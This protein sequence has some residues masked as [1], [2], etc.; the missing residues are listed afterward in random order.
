MIRS[1]M[2]D[3]LNESQ[4]NNQNLARSFSTGKTEFEELLK[5][6]ENKITAPVFRQLSSFA[7]IFSL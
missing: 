2:Q 1:V 4:A 3:D 5:F 6:C 7:I